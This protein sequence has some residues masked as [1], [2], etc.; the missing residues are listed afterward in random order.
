ME[1]IAPGVGGKGV[2]L[3]LIVARAEKK[4]RVAQT[5][6]IETDPLHPPLELGSSHCT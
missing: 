2:G 3:S 6:S 1:H 5:D 4:P